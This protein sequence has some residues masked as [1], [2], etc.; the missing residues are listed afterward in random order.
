MSGELFKS[1]AGIDMTH[2]PYEGGGPAKASIVAG[3][4]DVYASPC[5]TAKPFIEGGEVKGLAV[6]SKE[7]LSAMPDLPPAA[8]TISGFEFV[9]FYGL[10]VP[11]GTPT[12][13]QEKIRAAAIEAVADPKVGKQLTDLGFVLVDQGPEEFTDF[14]EEQ[15]AAAKAAV[16]Q[17]GI[18]PK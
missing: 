7:P 2:I 14:L 8:E 12:D 9:N 10:V 5:G 13:I 11:K 16:E 1:A 15:I 3:G 6:T 18:E 4:T 17:A